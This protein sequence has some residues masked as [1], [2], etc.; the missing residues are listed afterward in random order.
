MCAQIFA[1]K[2][3]NINLVATGNVRRS[4]KSGFIVLGHQGPYYEINKHIMTRI[5]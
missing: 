1:T 4:P 5:A 2:Y 3:E